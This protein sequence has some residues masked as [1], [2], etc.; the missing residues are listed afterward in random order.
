MCCSPGALSAEDRPQ[1]L[2]EVARCVVQT[3]VM[4]DASGH[5][6]GSGHNKAID[7]LAYLMGE[8]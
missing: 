7:D 8:L 4:G 3:R 1:A 5:F 2:V 6:S